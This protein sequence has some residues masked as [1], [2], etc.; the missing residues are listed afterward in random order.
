[1]PQKT[2]L[3][4]SPYYDDFDK[5]DNFYKVLFKPGFPVQAREL[6]GL[7]S[8]LQNQLESFGSH[9]F[10]E[11]SMVIPGGVTYDSSYF[12]V[13]VN[14]DHLGI[15][16]TIYLDSLV[17]NKVRIK[18]ENSQI[19]ASV[20]NYILPPEEDVEEIT[21]FVKYLE[22]GTDG[23]SVA[24]PDG[25]TIIIE[26]N[27]AYGN[28]TLNA[29]ESILTL[30]AN[31]ATATGSAVGVSEGVYFVRGTFVDV[32]TETIVLEPYSTDSSYRVGFDI[33]EEV[34]SANDEPDL[35]D[36][37]RG[38]TN[39][40]A[41]G[42]DRFK[43]SV[44][45]AKK[46]LDDYED[47]SFVE[48]VRI[49]NGVIKKLQDQSVYSELQ[50]YLAKRTFEESGNY[51]LDAFTVDVANSLNDEVGN[52]GLF[53]ETQKT[54][55]GNVPDDDTMCVKISPGKA[56]VRGFDI[57]LIGSTVIDVPKPRTTKSAS[58]LVPFTMGSL[59]KVNNVF[60]TPYINIGQPHSG[61]TNTIELFNELRDGSGTGGTTNAGSGKKIGDAR[62]YW[63]GVADAPYTGN[64]TEW[65]L[66]LFDVQ[67]YTDLHLAR[68]FST[69]ETPATSHVRG[70]SSGARG[71][72]AERPN[73]ACF[74]LTQTSGT[75][76]VGEQ[77]IIN[78][79]SELTTAITAINAYT[80]ED[81]K[82]VY[83][84][85]ATLN[86]AIQEDFLANAVLYDR[87]P[88]DFSITDKLTISGGNTATV[89]GRFF[90]AVT[91]IKTDAL[92]SYQSATRTDKNYNKITSIAANG[93]SLTVAAPT[94]SVTGVYENNVDNGDKNGFFIAAPRITD[95][96]EASL[97]EDLPRDNIASVDLTDADLRITR[98]ITGRS[99]NA[100]D[101]MTITVSDALDTS[102]GIT[103]VFFEPF[104]AERYSIHYEDG[105]TE[106]LTPDQFTLG[107]NAQSVTFTNLKTSESNVSVITTL[108][109]VNVTNKSKDYI[110]S[111]QLNVV[112]TSGVST[113]TGLS[114]SQFY[115]L[116]VEDVEISLNVADVAEVIA[117]YESTDNNAPT[118]DKLTFV[119]G[120]GLDQNA[121]TGERIVGKRSRAVAQVVNKTATTIDYVRLNTNAFEVG[122]TVEFKESNIEAIIQD[123]D[124]GSYVDRTE[125][126]DLDKGHREQFCDYSRLFRKFGSAVPNRQLLV[127]YNH[128]RAAA[129][130]AGDIFTCNSYTRDRYTNDIPI[131][132]G[133]GSR[134]TDV[135]D[136]RPRVADFTSTTSSPFAFSSRSYETTFRY[137]ISPDEASFVKYS[138]YL[139][140]VDLITL[141]RLGQVSVIT[142]TPSEDPE[143]PIN[144][145]DAMEIASIAY[146]AYLYDPAGEPQIELPDNRRF[147]MRDIAALE[148]RIINLEETT[149]L[150]LL[151]LETQALKVTDAQ[152]L[153]RFKTGFVVSDFR[154]DELVDFT[155]KDTRC[156]IDSTKNVLIAPVDFWSINAELALDP[157]IAKSTA[158][159]GSNLNLLDPNIQKTGDL[160]TLKY[161]Q[162]DWLEQPQATNVENV[163]PFNVIVFVGGVVL[164]PAA[165]NWTRT[166]YVN[167]TR[168][169]STGAKWVQTSKTTQNT[170]NFTQSGTQTY[171]R[172]RRRW[173]GRNKRSKGTRNVTQ[174]FTKTTTT[175]TY[176][177]KITGP[178]REYDYVE[179]VKVSSDVDPYMRSRN[180]YF[181][182]NGLK[183]FTKHYH[184]LDAQVLDLAPKITEI[185]MKSGTFTVFEDAKV[186]L[187][188]TQIGRMR[189]QAPD[190]KFGDT[191]RPDVGAGLGAP[192]VLVE[193]YTVD[194][195]DRTRNAPGSK[196]SPTSKLLN[197]DVR[198]LAN[199]QKYF[200]YLTRGVRIVGESSGAVAEVTRAELLSDNW[201]DIIG[202][203][204]F[205]EPNTTPKPP[206]LVRT[207]TKSFKV[208]ATPPGVT[209]LPGS[210]VFASSAVGTYSG[211]GVVITQDTSTVQMRNPPKP[212]SLPP[213]VNVQIKAA[214]R[215]PLAQSFTVDGEGVFLTSF[216]LFFATKDE[217]AKLFV[218]LRTVE[219]GTPTNFLVQDYTQIALN[220]S[221]IKTSS[222][223]TVP[224]NIK[225]PSPVYLEADKE[226]AIVLLSP[227]SDNYEVWTATMG[228]K[229]VRTQNLPDAQSVVVSKQY[230]GGSLF[231]SQNGT[232]WTPSQYQDLTFKLYKAKF[233][234]SGT[235]TFYN[236]DV[237][238]GGENVGKLDPNP[239][240]GL[241]RKLKLPINNSPAELKPGVRVGE[242]TSPSVNGIIENL[243]GPVGVLTAVTQG[244][245][246]PTG[247][248]TGVE[249]FSISGK[250]SGAEA[251][252]QFLNN[253]PHTINV[254][255]TG[256]GYIAG[257]TLGITTSSISSGSNSPGG[258]G[259]RFSVQD[260][261]A[262]FDT[263]YLTNV[264]GEN[265][266]NNSTIQRYVNPQ[267]ESSRTN[268]TATVNGTSTLIDLKYS[269]NVFEVQQ[270]NHAHHG[271]NN[272]IIVEGVL[273][274]TTAVKLDADFGLNDTTVSVA[275]TIPFSTFEGIS[276]TSGY[277]LLQ[278]EVV[279]YSSIG[280]GTLTINGRNLNGSQKTPH[281][282]GDFIQPYEAN[283]VS[284]MRINT[285]H[286]IPATYYRTENS[287]IDNY[288][289]EF[290]RTTPTVRST[291]GNMLNFTAEKGFGGNTVGISQNHQF[292]TLVP[293]FNVITPGKGT[294]VNA[295][296]RTISGTSAGGNEVSFLDQGYDPITLNRVVDFETPRL[297]ASRTNELERLTTFPSNKSLTLRVDFKT[298]NEDLSPQM[299]IQNS[300]FILG[301]NK[302]NKPILDY[303]TDDRSNKLSGDPHGCV[304]ITDRIYLDAPATSLR[305]L[306]GAN[307]EE[308]ADF[309]VF[310]RL[311]KADSSEVAQSYI[312]FPGYENLKDTDGDG[313]GDR[314]IDIDANTGSA[315]AK[316]PASGTQSYSSYQFTANN[317]DQF[318][319]FIIKVVTSSTNESTP[320]ELRDFRVIALA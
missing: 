271:G 185:D 65:D 294:S 197:I 102:S 297:V 167:K 89:P 93:T 261:N 111:T 69:A 243:G 195:Y 191:T 74:S 284:L 229:T 39:Y 27:I 266:T 19:V 92:I 117:V 289:L 181:A 320:V 113:V 68:E 97:Y 4:V 177:H 193:K 293:Q 178:S 230:I 33:L 249:L 50:K 295:N 98:Q 283:G 242:G 186:Y 46:S 253:V 201:G 124:Q 115:G 317:L 188:N 116:R 220:P 82:S 121:I 270:Y 170:Q 153:D 17:K 16:V 145:D 202:S 146:P 44:K 200:G 96:E 108:R 123:I 155:D 63:F 122:E 206:V 319:G 53:N 307:R 141:N 260:I 296:I 32:P 34:V 221:Y 127:V 94:S 73:L 161:E 152:G 302:V 316:V 314:V 24:F 66:Y 269:G 12:A 15:D 189:I 291:S 164:D 272:R 280:T 176:D 48:L 106:Q 169:E 10:K 298:E 251:T 184:N 71:Y 1:M 23:E 257:E 303:V 215:D 135:L 245:G 212:N 235:L 36:N 112:S 28:T 231:K 306:V 2:N 172:R 312:P 86:S 160:L 268:T 194:P 255:N 5:A 13:K 83:Q 171:R 179:S 301:R 246:Y 133:S 79:N 158:D 131:I 67:T 180:V 129:G 57:N 239:M 7:Q 138:Y 100:Q 72:I 132:D 3:N 287:N 162:V 214:H 234:K 228:K 88:A 318:N 165:D 290:D 77:I 47:T 223:A 80:V 313:Y 277:A 144:V 21:L 196:Y 38:F 9:I 11:G 119:A 56:Y 258:S 256:T 163:N 264:Q 205:R 107:G 120:L 198:S 81:I 279:S 103:S 85:T 210:T 304:F 62:V 151:E 125:G 187:G 207:G 128:Y 224:T 26:D 259:A 310:Y 58:A 217:D 213:K 236:S 278:N 20:K 31:N 222:D 299:D 192:S 292:S 37:A 166:I 183:P 51:A 248:F 41:P 225:F 273:P 55:D 64:E 219:L 209:P 30:V 203:F 78:E 76:Q 104:D 311:F 137:V 159:L 208:T 300:T 109:K 211:T 252:I 168:K 199:D 263:L 87:T 95:L 173:W 216:D 29:G 142:G 150:S 204:F 75:F 250:G 99:T 22:S 25:E 134:A 42:A 182:A 130:N 218:E 140:R 285:I 174:R 157:Q 110:R 43:I 267:D 308:D 282:K 281:S 90:N 262:S 14:P 309:R 54:D 315:D 114:T 59:L 275:N 52:R 91:G 147:T 40:A 274:D 232:I 84:D 148:R 240:K 244:S 286:D 18:G 60:G 149:S 226:Y 45:L 70:L 254:T 6:T 247:T 237:E 154:N 276:T 101:R 265:F 175:T 227:A 305:V 156:D 241:P 288:F 118:L 105:T 136:F 49:D 139:P 8:I 61:G 143:G 238:A 190:H 35:N 233:V 126:Y